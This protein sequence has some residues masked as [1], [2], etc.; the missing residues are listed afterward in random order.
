MGVVVV[1]DFRI[2]SGLEEA[3][4]AGTTVGPRVTVNASNNA[5]ARLKFGMDGFSLVIILNSPFL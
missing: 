2:V 1:A 4:K 3:A 5:T